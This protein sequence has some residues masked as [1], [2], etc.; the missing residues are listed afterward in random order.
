MTIAKKNSLL[1]T[2]P[3][4]TE[5]TPSQ[6]RSSFLGNYINANIRQFATKV[7]WF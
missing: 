5:S 6:E 4:V 7:L 3:P 1:L 2:A